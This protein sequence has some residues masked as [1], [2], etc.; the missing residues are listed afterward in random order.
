MFYFFISYIGSYHPNW[1]AHIFQRVAQP[2][3][4]FLRVSIGWFKGKITRNSHISLGNLWFP[5]DF[6]LSQPIESSLMNNHRPHFGFGPRG[7]AYSMSQ[8]RKEANEDVSS[9]LRMSRE[10]SASMGSPMNPISMDDLSCNFRVLSEF[11]S[12]YIHAYPFYV[13]LCSLSH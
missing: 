7:P 3:T 12:Q 2:P 4:S 1:R 5:V 11:Y 6:P 10:I 13:R 8:P 9:C